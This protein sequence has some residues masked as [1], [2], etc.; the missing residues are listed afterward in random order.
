MVKTK[1]SKK[2]AHPPTDS[3]S[4]E[5]YRG[6]SEEE[7]YTRPKQSTKKGTT[8]RNVKHRGTGYPPGQGRGTGRT[9]RGQS[10]SAL[11]DPSNPRIEPDNDIDLSYLENVM[12]T[13]RRP[14]R[15]RRDPPMVN[16]KRGGNSVEHLRYSED[17]AEVERSSIGD[18]RFWF[19]HQVI[20]MSL[21]SWPRSMSPLR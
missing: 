18:H 5:S 12:A 19:P 9:S 7:A 13:V 3:D 11:A 21:S 17:P 8:K 1:I 15:D 14:T 2:K 6:S 16:Y 20:G 4:D 10:S